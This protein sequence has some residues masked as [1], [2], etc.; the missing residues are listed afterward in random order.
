MT[1][2][3]VEAARDRAA[4]YE[5]PPSEIQQT[6]TLSVHDDLAAI[7]KEWRRFEGVADCTAFQT[8]D[9]VSTWHR[10]IGLRDGVRAA[11]V[12]GRFA[13][14]D[15]AFIMPLA[16]VV[17][18]LAT[19]LCWLAREV[20]DYN[21]PLLARDF[22]QRVAP[23]RF[24]AVWD[25]LLGL[26]QHDPLL[27]HDW[28]EL[29]K[30]PQTVGAQVNPF[31]FLDVKLNPSGAHLTHLS[32]DWEEFYYAKRSSATRRRDRTK[33]KHMSEFGE[34]RFVSAADAAEIRGTLATLM[35]QKS[36]SLARRGIADL[37]ADAG[38]REFFLDFAS[39][40]RTRHMVHVSRVDVGT[41]WAAANFGMVFGDCYYHVLA[42][43]NED[44]A[45]SS[46]GPGALH[47]RELLAYA[48]G[49]GLK[50]FDFTIGDERY[51]LE[52]SDTSLKL[53]DHAKVVTWRGLPACWSSIA[54]RR[55]KRF[56]K[57]TPLAWRV[58]SRVR[59]VL[60]AITRSRARADQR[61]S[62]PPAE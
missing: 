33:R 39:D 5:G 45:F 21:A 26:L 60:G 2:S 48:I 40:P 7:E 13:D 42:S 6:V 57:Q 19:R 9:W 12:V 14:G 25:D 61:Q 41:T 24:L 27:R 1:L 52:W 15:I 23:A 28:I 18:C 11:I 36:R 4:L 32:G 56:I 37:F 49:L 29:D 30:M 16:L 10:H 3:S 55:V 34:V 35:E 47:L 8:F 62:P 43:Y 46:Y 44:S 20:C 31:T 53:Y 54:W 22:S 38:R 51:K 50:R 59:I 17:D 58:A